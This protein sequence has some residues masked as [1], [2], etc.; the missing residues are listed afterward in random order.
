VL[1]KLTPCAGGPPIPLLKPKLVLGRLR[2]CD[3]PLCH[4]TVSSRHCQLELVDGYWFV[5]D[6]GSS[7]GTRVNGTR[8]AAE[9]LLPDDTLWV[10]SHRYRLSYHPPPDEPTPSRL[11]PQAEEKTPPMPPGAPADQ[12]KPAHQQVW[13]PLPTGPSLGELVPCGG[14]APIPLL[15]PRL[16]V[17]RGN[18]CDIVLRFPSVSRRHCELV[19][20]AGCWFVSDLGSHNGIRVDDIRCESGRLPPGSVLSIGGLRFAIVYPSQAPGPPMEAPKL[21]FSRALL[22]KAGLLGGP[23]SP[24]AGMRDE[25]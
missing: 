24:E 2:S 3:I 18:P 10:S 14:G 7:N 16:V 1:G 11:A 13:E 6:L 9:W 19:W 15:R 12:E 25:G 22:E 8:C 4:P 17:G 5:R 23:P 21:Q 20:A